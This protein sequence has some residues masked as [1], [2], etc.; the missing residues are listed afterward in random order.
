MNW[1]PSTPVK[2]KVQRE[3]LRTYQLEAEHHTLVMLMKDLKRLVNHMDSIKTLNHT[4]L[5]PISIN[6][7]INPTNDLRGT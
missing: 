6:T 5:K 3:K 4:F 2:N 7:G 1:L